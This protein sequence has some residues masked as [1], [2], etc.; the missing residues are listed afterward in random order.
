VV[1]S[2]L[3]L[4][5]QF[6]SAFKAAG[7]QHFTAVFRAHS[8]TETM[9]FLAFAHIRSERRSHDIAP[10]LQELN[11]CH[12]SRNGLSRPF[13]RDSI[14]KYYHLNLETYPHRKHLYIFK[15]VL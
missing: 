8:C 3:Y 13:S 12:I 6:L 4:R 14:Y 1:L 15:H 10:P 7:C 11:Y 9:H 2:G 5:T